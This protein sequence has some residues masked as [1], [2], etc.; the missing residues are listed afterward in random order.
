[1]ANFFRKKPIVVEAFRVGIDEVPEWASRSGHFHIISKG[2]DSQAEVHTLEGIMRC[3]FGDYII[4]G[5]FG[6][7]YPCRA[8]VFEDTYVPNEEECEDSIYKSIFYKLYSSL[9]AKD[10][11][12]VEQLLLSIEDWGR[13]NEDAELSREEAKK[14]CHLILRKCLSK[15]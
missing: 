14:A 15:Q 8:D 12:K 9:Y 10:Y 1:M 5:A 11:Q 4:K 3:Y 13:T 6:E 2:K 7:L